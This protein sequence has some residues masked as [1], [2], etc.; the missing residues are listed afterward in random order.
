MLK[1]LKAV[2]HKGDSVDKEKQQLMKQAVARAA[3]E[4]VGQHDVI[5][6]GTGTTV[7]CFIE[8]LA[9]ASSNIEGA[10]ASS[11]DTARR[12]KA[13]GIPVLDLNDVGG[14]PIYIDGADEFNRFG[15]LTKGGGGA[16]TREKIIAAS[17]RKFVCMVDQYKE[18]EI[19]GAFPLPV[20]VIPMARSYVTQPSR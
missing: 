16:L 13:A 8:A 4:E 17:A 6:V 19:L 11:E 14:V 15:Y 5:G 18:V 3:V 7:Q 9:D 12:L 1:H 2:F 20:A 10:V